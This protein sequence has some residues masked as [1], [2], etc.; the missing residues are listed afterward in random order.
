MSAGVLQSEGLRRLTPLLLLLLLRRRAA[1]HNAVL[2]PRLC[3][4][5]RCQPLL[6]LRLR[7]RR[8]L[9]LWRRDEA[10]DSVLDVLAVCALDGIELEVAQKCA[11]RALLRASALDRR[12]RERDQL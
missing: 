12:R 9:L 6:L 1:S 11:R 4:R 2:L 8:R 5:R 7:L 3:T 10:D